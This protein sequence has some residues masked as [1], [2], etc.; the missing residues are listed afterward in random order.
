VNFDLHVAFGFWTLLFVAIWGLTGLYFGFPFHF[1]RVVA[2]FTPIV[3][4]PRPS[5]WKPGHPVLP[6]DQFIER[7]QT[8]FPGT[9]LVFLTYGVQDKNGSIVVLLSQNRRIPL[10]V[11]RD[12]GTDRCAPLHTAPV[13]G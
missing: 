10:E 9:E 8:T 5:Q 2:M 12:T 13:L 1:R 7:A 4:M 3:E 11:A 6:V